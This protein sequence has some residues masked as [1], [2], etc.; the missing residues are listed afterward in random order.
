MG[1]DEL[2][3][4]IAQDI[5]NAIDD[6]ST[7]AQ[8]KMHEAEIDLERQRIKT[9]ERISE[10]MAERDEHI[11]DTTAGVD[12]LRSMFSSLMSRL[13]TFMN[14]N[15]PQVPIIHTEVNPTEDEND[16]DENDIESPVATEDVIP[17]EHPEILGATVEEEIENSVESP[18]TEVD[19][20][21]NEVVDN[22]KPGRNRRR[23]RSRR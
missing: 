13:D 6:T 8:L 11:A 5:Q 15:M 2:P 14:N 20:L 16:D 23:K 18:E 7:D 10:R 22:G 3:N 19:Q 1:I 4:Q 21:E 17:E 12:E 9:E